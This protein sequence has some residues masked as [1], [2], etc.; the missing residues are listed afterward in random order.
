ML[1]HGF[2]RI[3]RD[4]RDED[5]QRGCD[6]QIDVVEACTA[7]EDGAHAHI[8]QRGQHRRIEHVIDEDADGVAV[9]RQQGCLQRQGGFQVHEGEAR[10]AASVGQ[11]LVQ[12]AT[13][14]ALRAEY[15]DLHPTPYLGIDL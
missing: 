10:G 11:R 5:A 9:F 2:G 15:G 3:G 7:Q 6:L 1:G 4:A 14:I 13:V 12:K 8:L